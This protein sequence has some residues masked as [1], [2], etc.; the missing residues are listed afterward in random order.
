MK[1]IRTGREGRFGID[2]TFTAGFRRQVI[3]NPATV[4]HMSHIGTTG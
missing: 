3:R 4:S 2:E 1:A